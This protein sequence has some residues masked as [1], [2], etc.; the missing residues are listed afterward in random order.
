MKKYKLLLTGNNNTAIDD[1]FNQMGEFFDMV[2]TSERFSD[3][4]NHLNMMQFDAMLACFNSIT[5]DEISKFSELKR[6]LT[7][8][9]VYFF[10]FG[11]QENCNDFEN[12]AVYM[13]D[14]SFI[15]P[16][17]IRDIKD[18]ILDFIHE[19]EHEAEVAAREEEEKQ[20]AIEMLKKMEEQKRR[21]HV[22]VIDDDPIV[23]KMIKEHLHDDYDVAT[24]ISGKIA[25]KFLENK[26]TDLIL[27]D[28]ELPVENGPEI[29]TNIRQMEKMANKPVVFLTGVSDVEKI[30]IV[31]SLKPQGYLLKPIDRDKLLGT[32]EKIFS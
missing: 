1:F 5:R 32:I 13:V 29:L 15:R 25:Y 17:S 12:G 28:Y 27:L 7:K 26:D 19:R 8:L 3:M 30:K 4:D 14:K 24:A 16:A 31:L 20:A 6:K 21:K 23:L 18:G 2:S 11:S 10:I 9:G 22:L